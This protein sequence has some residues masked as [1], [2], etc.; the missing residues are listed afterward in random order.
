MRDWRGV[1]DGVGVRTAR[2][3]TLVAGCADDADGRHAR[4]DGAQALRCGGGQARY[5]QD[6][7]DGI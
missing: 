6:V 5:A 1:G 4:E 7:H 3:T 2:P